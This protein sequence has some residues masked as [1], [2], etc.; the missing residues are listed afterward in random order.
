M[1]SKKVSSSYG[2]VTEKEIKKL[3]IEGKKTILDDKKYL[4][5]LHGCTNYIKF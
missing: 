1:A 5:L 3:F 2:R 4:T